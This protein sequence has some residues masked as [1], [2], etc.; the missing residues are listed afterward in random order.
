MNKEL[1][2]DLTFNGQPFTLTV[3]QESE[4][5]VISG[6]LRCGSLVVPIRAGV[7]EFVGGGDSDSGAAQVKDVFSKYWRT[8]ILD[9]QNKGKV[10]IYT[11]GFRKLMMLDLPDTEKAHNSI[12]GYLRGKHRIL[13]A[14]C[15]PGWAALYFRANDEQRWYSVDFG[16][17]SY[18]AFE[19]LRVHPNNLVLRASLFE[20]PFPRE[21]FDLIISNGVLH[22]TPDPRGGFKALVR[23]LAPGGEIYLGLI[24]RQT[25]IRDFVDGYVRERT[26]EMTLDD[27]LKFADSMAKLGEELQRHNVTIQVPAGLELLGIDA[28]SYS[29]HRFIHTH[30]VKCFHSPSLSS[31]EN[32]MQNIDWY[33][34]KYA[35][36]HTEEQIV[37]WYKEEGLTDIELWTP[38]QA[39]EKH[40]MIRIRGRKPR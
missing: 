1:V 32:R 30:M 15:G 7:P 39:S 10:G 13:D 17:S 5:H 19:N 11:E 35:W 38:R 29:L 36:P 18:L 9:G 3:K 4:G 12:A 26:T 21:F 6:E 16:E 27:N 37:Q 28:G 20:L 31:D 24:R 2:S 25:P 14:G 33:A 8:H 23:H 22:H 40:E 34:V